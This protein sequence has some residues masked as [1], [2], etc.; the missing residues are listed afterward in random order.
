MK[1]GNCNHCNGF[2]D[3]G[4]PDC[5]FVD[6]C[7]Y[8]VEI[9]GANAT[10]TINMDDLNQSIKRNLE[11]K[12]DG[13]VLQSVEK[14]VREA[15]KDKI[16]ELVEQ[17]LS[18]KLDEAVAEYLAGEITVGGGWGSP[19][20]K[21]TRTQLM[22]E[23]VQ[24]LLDKTFADKRRVSDE[25]VKVAN[26]LITKSVDALKRDVQQRLSTTFDDMTR[27]NLA[28]NVVAMLMSSN[29]YR[30]LRDNMKNLLHG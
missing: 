19:E 20:K 18:S 6:E 25:V 2:D 27:Q 10:L 9:G 11:A 22:N 15:C 8:D 23:T 24:E 4:Y 26:P 21:V 28:D 3:V 30:Q 7:P 12:I 17:A 16:E 29:T 13:V 14:I 1:C 5:E